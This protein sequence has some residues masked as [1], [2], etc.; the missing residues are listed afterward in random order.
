MCAEIMPKI[1]F[2]VGACP[3]MKS[4]FTN[5]ELLSVQ[6]RAARK[7]SSSYIEF[8]WGV[9]FCVSFFEQGIWAI[10]FADQIITGT[11]HALKLWICG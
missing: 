7:S 2:E 6:R 11:M 4:C 3:L 9:K 1:S 5:L 8:Q 10:F